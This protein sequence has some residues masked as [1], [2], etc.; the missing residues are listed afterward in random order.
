MMGHSVDFKSYDKSHDL[1]A[2]VLDLAQEQEEPGVDP[3][4]TFEQKSRAA[5][6]AAVVADLRAGAGS[7]KDI[8]ALLNDV[9]ADARA[10]FTPVEGFKSVRSLIRGASSDFGPALSFLVAQKTD[11]SWLALR[12]VMNPF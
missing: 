3:K 8:Q 5:A 11:G 4:D 2:I 10:V 1:D 7:D 12:Y 9:A 6:V